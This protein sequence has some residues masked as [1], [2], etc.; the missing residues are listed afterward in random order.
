MKNLCI[1]ALIALTASFT[2]P[3]QTARDKEIRSS[4]IVKRI[5]IRGNQRIPLPQIKSW[6]AT[7]KNRVYTPEELDQDIR[8]L[9]DTGHFDDVKVYVEQGLHGGKIVTFE[10]MERPLI[11]D[12]AFEGIDSSLRTEVI[13][14]WRK[15]GIEL[16]KGS[17]FE[18][19]TIR[20]AAKIMQD[21][22]V[23]KE[24]W[25]IKL[26]PH[27]E[28]QTANEVLIVFKVEFPSHR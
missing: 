16:V 3:A 25:D 5:L 11:H 26:I 7:Q 17:E 8:A 9:Y 15:R 14:E 10:L 22:L 19:L 24:H 18:P 2:S 4:Q 12:I 1:A 28:R 20:R 6:I 23:S 27:V 13:E 21:L